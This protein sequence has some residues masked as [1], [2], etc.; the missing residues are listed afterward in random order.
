MW[1]TRRRVSAC[2]MDTRCKWGGLWAVAV[3]PGA[4]AKPSVTPALPWLSRHLLQGRLGE[5]WVWQFSG[6][7]GV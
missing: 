3:S 7:G 5:E 4:V 2:Q 1:K 6:S